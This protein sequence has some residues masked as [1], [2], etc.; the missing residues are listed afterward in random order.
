MSNELIYDHGIDVTL[1]L[2]AA[3]VQDDSSTAAILAQTGTG[4]IVPTGYEAHPVYLGA[5]SNADLTAG[6]ATWQVTDNGTV[7]ANGP[8]VVLADT[9]QEGTGVARVGA[10]PIAAGRT[11]GAKVLTS[12]TYAPET[13]DHDVIL[14]LKILPA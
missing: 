11:V 6:T 4:F 1:I 14:I 7:L 3:N 12:A 9:V 2:S 13:A 5:R 8:S 10:A